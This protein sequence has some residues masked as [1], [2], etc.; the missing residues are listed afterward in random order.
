MKGSHERAVRLEFQDELI[1]SRER[2]EGW[3]ARVEDT[4]V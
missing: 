3:K 1:H 2:L 4:P